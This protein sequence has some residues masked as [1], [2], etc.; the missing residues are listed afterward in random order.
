MSNKISVSFWRIIWLATLVIGL[1]LLTNVFVA[2]ASVYRN[3]TLN[4]VRA[5]SDCT[6][7]D[8]IPVGTSPVTGPDSGGKWQ[9][10]GEVILMWS[11]ACSMN[12]T[13]FTK[14]Q[15]PNAQ[16]TIQALSIYLYSLG[17]GKISKSCDDVA[18]GATNECQTSPLVL[19]NIPAQAVAF[20]TAYTPCTGDNCYWKAYGITS[21]Y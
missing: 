8:G 13:V 15:D 3:A 21:Q 16:W 11:S 2:H 7:T 18:S 9:K 14:N 19:N 1:I 4:S 5:S 12:W 6:P 20:A 17:G 10:I